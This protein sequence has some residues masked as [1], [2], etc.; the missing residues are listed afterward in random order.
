[1]D[2]TSSK[3]CEIDWKGKLSPTPCFAL[4]RGQDGHEKSAR[5]LLGFME[6]VIELLEMERLTF[7]DVIKSGVH[8]RPNQR[9]GCNT[10][11]SI[12]QCH[13]DE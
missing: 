11:G 2:Q 9:I 10:L 13:H 6:N 1:M 5:A 8:T 7:K 12:C 4:R 3:D